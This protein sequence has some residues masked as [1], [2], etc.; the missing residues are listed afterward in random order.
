MNLADVKKGIRLGKSKRRVGRGAGS[1]LGK[2]SGRGHKGLNARAGKNM[3]LTY[4][5]G[6]TPLFQRIA[7]RGF[8]NGRFKKSFTVVNIAQLNNFEDGSVVGLEQLQSVG[9]ADN[10]RDGLRILGF[11]TL[12][13]KLT[14]KAAA[15]SKSA[16]A[17][18]EAAGGSIEIVSKSK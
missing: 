13:K 14:V 6:Q 8:T 17:S 11:G 10:P 7:K 4:E 5:G 12:E 2:T 18:I 3:A 16:Q 1:G 15:F 9:L